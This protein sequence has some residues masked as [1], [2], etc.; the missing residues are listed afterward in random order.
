[1]SSDGDFP[2]SVDVDDFEGA[3]L[4]FFVAEASAFAVPDATLFFADVDLPV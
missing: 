3:G 4:G 2:E 1:M